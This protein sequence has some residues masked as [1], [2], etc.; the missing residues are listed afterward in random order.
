MNPYE[1][2]GVDRNAKDKTIKKAYMEMTRKWHPDLYHN[3]EDIKIANAKMQ[4]INAAWELIGSPK[5]RAIYDKEHPVSVY[6]YYA[7]KTS[8]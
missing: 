5:S 6:E 2:L 3:E 8:F 1:I 7:K 4:E